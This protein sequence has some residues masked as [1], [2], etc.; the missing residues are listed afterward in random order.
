MVGNN[1][2]TLMMPTATILER[3]YYFLC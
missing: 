2:T 1:E 3:F